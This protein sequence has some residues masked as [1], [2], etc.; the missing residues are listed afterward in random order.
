MADI[1]EVRTPKA[2]PFACEIV[3]MEA[4]GVAAGWRNRVSGW[5]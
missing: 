2:S 3:S 5:A 4:T 1:Y